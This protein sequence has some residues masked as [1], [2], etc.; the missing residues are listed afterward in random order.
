MSAFI[1]ALLIK[2][3]I[4]LAV[5]LTIVA[6]LRAAAPS[7]KHIVLFATLTSTLLLPLAMAVSPSWNVPVLPQRAAQTRSQASAVAGATGETSRST[8]LLEDG[9]RFQRNTTAVPEADLQSPTVANSRSWA[10]RAAAAIPLAWALGCFAVLA[11]LTIGRVR[12][13]RIGTSAWPLDSADW[14]R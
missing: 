12:L 14:T 10:E 6:V 5:G 8:A 9:A 11:W 7:L 4:V 2:V 3:T 13:S 1:P